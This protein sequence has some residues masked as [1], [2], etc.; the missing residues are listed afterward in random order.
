MKG[1]KD[2]LYLKSSQNVEMLHVH[3]EG[4]TEC[5]FFM[6]TLSIALMFMTPQ[7]FM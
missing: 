7:I 1:S 2:V 6:G 5:P 3:C 4:N